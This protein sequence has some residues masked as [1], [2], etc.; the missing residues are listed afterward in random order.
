MR[1]IQRLWK[2]FDT[3]KVGIGVAWPESFANLLETLDKSKQ[4]AM[5]AM[6]PVVFSLAS[7]KPFDQVVALER[8]TPNARYGVEVEGLRVFFSSR[9]M[10]YADTPNL[11]I[12]A[13]P[14]FV[15]ERGL[16]AL[17]VFIQVM[18]A[19]LGGE[20]LWNKVSEVHMTADFEVDRPHIDADYRMDEGFA[21]VTRAR[22]KAKRYGCTMPS[23]EQD[24][25]REETALFYKGSRL[26]TLQIGKNQLM[27]R[28][29]DKQ[30]ELSR[31]PRKCWERLL[32]VNCNA[33]HVMRVEYQVRREV[34]RLLGFDTVQDL[35]QRQ[36]NLWGYLTKN[37]FRLYSREVVKPGS[38]GIKVIHP[39]WMAV[40]EAWGLE[41][42]PAFRQKQFHELRV[43]RAQQLLGHATSLAAIME[44]RRRCLATDVDSLLLL[45]RELLVEL[46]APRDILAEVSAKT[47]RFECRNKAGLDGPE[48]GTGEQRGM[49]RIHTR[50]RVREFTAVLPP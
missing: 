22:T 30:A 27:L 11:Y 35:L 46:I 8:G 42:E 39:F 6:E 32:W 45:M 26:E 41:C 19:R 5:D 20:Y 47:A 48:N 13:G 49:L 16:E 34:L 23:D 12:E 18:I 24:D 1:V 31:R 33:E 4:Q 14:A 38:K 2:G 44:P 3:I 17:F 43:Q 50:R 25:S 7:E 15:A 9:Q 28:I 40:E 37:W 29:Y 10:P 21:F 36:D